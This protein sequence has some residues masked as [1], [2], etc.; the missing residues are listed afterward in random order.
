MTAPARIT[1]LELLGTYRYYVERLARFTHVRS[2]TRLEDWEEQDNDPKKVE[3][4]R[5]ALRQ[6][7]QEARSAALVYDLQLQWP[8]E[9]GLSDDEE[10]ACR[11]ER[12]R[13]HREMRDV[14]RVTGRTPPWDRPTG[15]RH[16]EPS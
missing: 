7:A 16:E 9:D 3:W 4:R 5:T 2:G 12:D 15:T 6:A 10:K 1:A 8:L 13:L 14:W 11:D